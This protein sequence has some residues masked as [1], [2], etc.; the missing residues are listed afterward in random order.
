[1]FAEGRVPKIGIARRWTHH[2]RSNGR[3]ASV[4]EDVAVDAQWTLSGRSV[5]ATVDA[6]VDSIKTHTLVIL[7][8]KD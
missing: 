6:T 1:M 2:G 3:S 5:D 7:I 4:I 8:E